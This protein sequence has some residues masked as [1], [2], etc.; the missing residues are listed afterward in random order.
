MEPGLY[1]GTTI[2]SNNIFERWLCFNFAYGFNEIELINY[3]GVSSTNGNTVEDKTNEA[4][5]KIQFPA[6]TM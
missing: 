4:I 5:K 3:F 2:Y 1:H 6:K